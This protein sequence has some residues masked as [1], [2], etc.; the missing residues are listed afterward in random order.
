VLTG[1]RAQ[2]GTQRLVIAGDRRLAP[3][4]GA[5]LGNIPARPALAEQERSPIAATGCSGGSS[6]A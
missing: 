5:V 4:G 6:S 3:L 2:L 1:D